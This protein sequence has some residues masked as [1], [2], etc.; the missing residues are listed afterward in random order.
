MKHFNTLQ[1]IFAATNGIQISAQSILNRRAHI[2][3]EYQDFTVSDELSEQIIESILDLLGGWA[4]NRK[5][6]RSTLKYGTPQH[7]G[8]SRI[9]LESYGGEE[10]RFRYCAGQDYPAELREIRKY[11]TK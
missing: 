10:P 3:G 5:Y 11:L 8:L 4:K 6:M 7:W 9:F 1:E 2:F